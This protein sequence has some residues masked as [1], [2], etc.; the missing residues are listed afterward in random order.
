MIV[1]NNQNREWRE[2]TQDFNIPAYLYRKDSNNPIPSHN[3][4]NFC[5]MYHTEG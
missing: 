2:L 3:G 5:V 4:K 1:N